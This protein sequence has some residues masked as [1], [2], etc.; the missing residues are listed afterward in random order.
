[1]CFE[2][3]YNEISELRFFLI[4]YDCVIKVAINI[5]F[6]YVIINYLKIGF[7]FV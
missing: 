2:V 4:R 1:M 3:I 6:C 5:I 7:R